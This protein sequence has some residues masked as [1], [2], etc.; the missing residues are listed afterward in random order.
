VNGVKLAYRP[1][2]AAE[3]LGVDR[4]TIHRLISRGELTSFTVG[5]ARC[6]AAAELERFIRER[7][8]AST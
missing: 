4:D 2:E 1:K 8:G 5:R 3:A 6:I 7:E